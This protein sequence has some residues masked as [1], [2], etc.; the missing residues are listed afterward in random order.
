MPAPA[1][2]SLLGAAAALLLIVACSRAW[3]AYASS[4]PVEGAVDVSVKSGP[5][6]LVRSAAGQHVNFDFLL[7]NRTSARLT[8]GRVELSILDSAGQL[9]R[10]EFHDE[11]S[12]VSLEL[13]PSR[14]VRPGRDIVLFNP[15]HTF[16]SDVPIATLRYEFEFRTGDR[17]R[18]VRTTLDVRPTIYQQKT[19]LALPI[20]GRVL[21]WD[22]HDY[23][24]HHRRN[25]Y[26]THSRYAYDFVI[27]DERGS[28]YRGRPR[29]S[30]DWF[31]AR[32]DEVADYY[33]FGAPVYA[34]GAGRVVLVKD[35]QPDDRTWN[36][37]DLATDENSPSGNYIVIDHLNGEF[38]AFG[39]LKRGS[40]RVRVGQMVRQGEEIAA[41][42]QSGSSL[43]PHL[44][45]E[46]RDGTGTLKAQGLPSNFSNFR[47]ML[48]S[49]PVSV[50]RGAINTG[51]IVDWEEPEGRRR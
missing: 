29:S 5:V 19:D 40:A 50:P 25:P 36:E 9:V 16:A 4:R 18:H 11:R 30:D 28:H 21:V 48:G 24:A 49:R 38:S 47:R 15:F 23:H 17:E 20:R 41:I 42:G 45:Y 8:L 39:H 14:S 32:P 22:G 31:Q 37:A 26:A 7:A 33:S 3:S 51:D 1:R 44:H 27:V 2:K 46:L 10:R 12:R 13:T 34:A 6:H 35:T 43:F